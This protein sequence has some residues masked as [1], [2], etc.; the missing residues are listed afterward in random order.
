M[1]LGFI[2][3]ECSTNNEPVKKK[4]QSLTE[5][6]FNSTNRRP[7]IDS[8]KAEKISSEIYDNLFKSYSNS[9]ISNLID[10]QISSDSVKVES[11]IYYY[12]F[13]I[14]YD[15][16]HTII[17]DTSQV[18]FLPNLVK[19]YNPTIQ[20]YRN[21]EDLL[22]KELKNKSSEYLTMLDTLSIRNY[23]RQYSFYRQTNNDSMVYINGLCEILE[24]PA[25]SDGEII[26]KPWNW[27]DELISVNDGGDCYWQVLINLTSR[28]VEY[29][30]INGV[31]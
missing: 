29:L 9:K 21:A 14:A 16:R 20:D 11:L 30:M 1:L 5:N 25:E 28:K 19:F 15:S 6:Y 18:S 4:L 23:Y 31:A 10:S 26:W 3:W 13:P 22:I 7:N 24:Y 27:K 12:S 17:S 2:L 8:L